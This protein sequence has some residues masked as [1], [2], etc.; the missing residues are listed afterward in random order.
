MKLIDSHAHIDAAEFDGDRAEVMQRASDSGIDGI[1]VI[2][3]GASVGEAQR[4]VDLAESA[5][6]LWATVGIHPHH[7]GAMNDEWLDELGALG[8]RPAVVGIGETGLDYHY[9]SAPRDVQ[10]ARFS[11]FVALAAKLGKP[12]ICHIRDAHADARRILAEARAGAVIHC[13]TGGPQDAAAYVEMGFAISFSGI[14]TFRNAGDIR[15]AVGVVPLDKILLETDCPYLAPV[16]M[17]GKRNEPSFLV[18]TA[19]VVA[20]VLGID[21]ADLAAQTVANTR[22]VL[23]LT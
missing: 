5:P 2:G 12:V 1:V 14:V 15:A 20:D 22:Q 7:V 4:A 11:Q 6:G 21:V 17:R 13:F 23:A 3:S 19:Q 8:R 16:P 10:A 9:D 18:H